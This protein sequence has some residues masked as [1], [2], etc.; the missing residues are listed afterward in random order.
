MSMLRRIAFPLRLVGA[1][2]GAGGRRSHHVAAGVVA[3]A[4][5]V[6]AV[7]GGR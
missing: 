6:A 2:L 7:L 1:R 3:G 5:L 4:A